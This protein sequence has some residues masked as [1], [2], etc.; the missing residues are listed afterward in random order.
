V[1]GE[2]IQ[3]LRRALRTLIYAGLNTA[4]AVE[5]IS[6]ELAGDP[7]V[8]FLVAFVTSA[9]RGFVKAIPGRRG[10]RGGG[11]AGEE[12][13]AGEDADAADPS[14]EPVAVPESWEGDA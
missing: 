7:E 11:E 12:A 2:T 9:R 1:P 3:R 8:A 14:A 13:D 6:A 5:R 10:E 4:Q